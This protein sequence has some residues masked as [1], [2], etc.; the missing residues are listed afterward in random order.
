MVLHLMLQFSIVFI[1][2]LFSL[3][4]SSRRDLVVEMFLSENCSQYHVRLACL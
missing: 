2:E 4:S 3:L 1:Q